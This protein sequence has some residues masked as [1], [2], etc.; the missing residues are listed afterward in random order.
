MT[1]AEKSGEGQGNARKKIR[2][3]RKKLP[4]KS[5]LRALADFFKILGD[6]TRLR[7]LWALSESALCVGDLCDL[8]KMK[9]PAVSHQLKTLKLSRI[10]KDTREGKVVTYTLDDEHIRQ[11]LDL[12]M[13]HLR[14][15]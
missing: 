5:D 15:T 9:Q 4:P 7:I 12:G 11:L 1:A 13:E 2:S 8:L 6:G 14:E 10:V 3:V